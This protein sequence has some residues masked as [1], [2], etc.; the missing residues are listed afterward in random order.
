[1]DVLKLVFMSAG[2]FSRLR[3]KIARQHPAVMRKAQSSFP[4]LMD[5]RLSE[6]GERRGGREGLLEGKR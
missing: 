2:T 3:L 5:V 1:M 4:P 6:V